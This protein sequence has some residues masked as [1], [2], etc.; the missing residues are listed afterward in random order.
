MRL[1]DPGHLAQIDKIFNTEMSDETASW[2]LDE[3]G[4]WIHHS[5]SESG[6]PLD[7]AQEVTMRAIASRKRTSGVLR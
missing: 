4:I 1:T 2:W 7:D 5:V 6:A 3:S